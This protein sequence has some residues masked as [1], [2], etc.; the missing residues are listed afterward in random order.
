MFRAQGLIVNKWKMNMNRQIINELNDIDF[1]IGTLQEMR[2][3]TVY[4]FEREQPPYGHPIAI[5]TRAHIERLN[6]QIRLLRK[7]KEQLLYI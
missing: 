5:E 2:D 4:H 3:L 1:E 7:R 6:S